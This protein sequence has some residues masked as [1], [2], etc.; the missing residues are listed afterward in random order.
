MTEWQSAVFFTDNWLN[1]FCCILRLFHMVP[2]HIQAVCVRGGAGVFVTDCGLYLPNVYARGGLLRERFCDCVFQCVGEC[3]C[4]SG[5]AKRICACVVAVSPLL[6]L[7]HLNR[8]E[9]RRRGELN[10]CS[11]TARGRHPPRSSLIKAHHKVAL[12]CL[13]RAPATTYCMGTRAYTS[14]AINHYQRWRGRGRERGEETGSEGKGGSE[15]G[16]GDG[17]GETMLFSYYPLEITDQC[18]NYYLEVKLICWSETCP[19]P[20]CLCVCVC[21]SVCV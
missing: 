3:D 19:L 7:V 1:V 11:V 12:C 8:H 17:V 4:E 5:S 14:S 20:A 2:H 6:L 18:H 10:V 9:G 16:R 13:L 21:V 15:G